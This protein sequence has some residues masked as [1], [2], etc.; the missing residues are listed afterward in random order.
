MTSVRRYIK[1]SFKAQNSSKVPKS[2]KMDNYIVK[3][4]SLII[5]IIISA[6]VVYI[7]KNYKSK[8]ETEA[9]A[10]TTPETEKPTESVLK[11]TNIFVFISVIFALSVLI[12][13]IVQ[14]IEYSMTEIMPAII[15]LCY[16][17]LFTYYLSYK[18]KIR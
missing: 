2:L 8:P 4:I 3:A 18:N 16:I 9:E 14:G 13:L 5:V 7:I 17:L 10:E 12:A 15:M 6:M 1:K 11:G